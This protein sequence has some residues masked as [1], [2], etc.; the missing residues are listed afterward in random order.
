MNQAGTGYFRAHVPPAGTNKKLYETICDS[1]EK[2][3]T[4]A[5]LII[6][7]INENEVAVT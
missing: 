2:S 6:P 4:R 3:N 5:I 7:D 1:L